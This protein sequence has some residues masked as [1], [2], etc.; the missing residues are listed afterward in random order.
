M[1][2]AEPWIPG[3]DHLLLQPARHILVATLAVPMYKDGKPVP[4]EGETVEGEENVGG[5]DAEP[6]PGAGVG[7]ELEDESG[8]DENME[9][10]EMSEAD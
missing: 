5:Q 8:E 6:D 3:K 4:H 9:E 10:G 2:R 7:F 1:F